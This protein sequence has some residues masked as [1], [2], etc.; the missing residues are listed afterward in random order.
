MTTNLSE[1]INS[2]LKGTRNLPF[3]QKAIIAN[4]ERISHMLVTS[5]ERAV[6]I[7]AVDEIVAVGVQSRFQVYLEHR[8]CDCSYFQELHYPCGHA[9]AACAFARLDW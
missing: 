8:R 2:V 1:C 5:F 4:R 9:L 6:S 7:F 3:L